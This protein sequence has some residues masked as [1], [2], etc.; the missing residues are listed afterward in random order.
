M[1]N[2]NNQDLSKAL[3]DVLELPTIEQEEWLARLRTSNPELAEEVRAL[4]SVRQQAWFS[5]FLSGRFPQPE[6]AE[7]SSMLG[8]QVGAYEIDGELG[9]GGMGSVWRAHRTDGRFQGTVALKF[10]HASWLGRAGEERFRHEGTLLGR[11]Q[12]PNI[13]RLLDAG[14]YEHQPYLVLEYVE[15][16]PIDTYCEERR[17]NLV[18]RC[19]LFGEVLAAVAHAHSH[20]IVHRDLKPSNILVTTSGDV[21]LLDF[22]LAKLIE[23][24]PDREATQLSAV[25]LTP[26]YASPEQL[27]A[28]PVTTASDV[29]SL[30][31]LLYVVL[32]GRHPGGEVVRMSA[33]W[34]QTIL[35]EEPRRASDCP[36]LD[37]ARRRA[38]QGD[39]DNILGKAL[40]RAPEER[41]G[42][43][44]AFAEDV[45]RYLADEPVHAVADTRVYRIRKFLKRHR[46]GVIAAIL[47]ILALSATTVFALLQMFEAR[48]QR[49]L[50]EY[51]ANHASAQNELTSFLLGDALSEESR[52]A[53]E[54]RLNRAHDMIHRRFAYDKHLQAG[55]L[56][57]L[58]GRYIDAGDM[59]GG[60]AA[61]QEAE[62]LAQSL[63]D[64]DLKASIACG[65]AE[66][67][68]EAGDL[69]AAHRE[70]HEGLANIAR[71]S[72][73]SPGLK[74]SCATATAFIA[75]RENDY[76]KAIAV[77]GETAQALRTAGVEHT[78]RYTSI[79]H[80][81]ARAQVLAGHFREGWQAEEAVIKEVAAL[82][83]EGS[84]GYFAMIN[85]G[86][87]ALMEGGAPLKARALLDNAAKVSS[88]E[89]PSQGL[90]FYL[91][92]SRILAELYAGEAHGAPAKLLQSAATADKE[93]LFTAV[94]TYVSGA[95]RAALDLDD[96]SAAARALEDSQALLSAHP[97][98]RS[99]QL[100]LLA[101]RAR[102]ASAQ[103]DGPKAMRLI[104]QARELIPAAEQRA[105]RAWSILLF[106]AV[107]IEVAQ[108]DLVRASNDAR[109]AVEIARQRAIDP[110]SSRW[111]GEALYW[112]ARIEAA[113]GSPADAR[114]DAA[115]ALSELRA[116]VLPGSLLLLRAQKFAASI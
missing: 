88:P 103:G 51:E 10:V 94:P 11:L 100:R 73:P 60:A 31:L 25:A 115:Q 53:V 24:G 3:D 90:P 91:E 105:E 63:D 86:A 7:T 109:E 6:T 36:E 12:H 65:K 26:Q 41:Y 112:R 111:L 43:A 47:A 110:K 55:L 79:A 71:V 57:G 76:P 64:P 1:S 5:E 66:D 27:L 40:K 69:A 35:N 68:V 50:A 58:S 44:Q 59:K 56:I 83:R 54:M 87:T 89:M 52:E 98:G 84:N 29:Y 32:T 4:L 14:V 46:T 95:V 72:D 17:L 74:A 33:E 15:G 116:S 19:T 2:S 107:E 113:S 16:T 37:P 70:E 101:A 114:A 23:E 18:E 67:A 99:D 45:G 97:L 30:G 42:S 75:E 28:Q 48:E 85:V 106:A 8:R 61:M 39:L 96:P 21:K 49:D 22:G 62:A 77:L 82:G 78:E 108:G 13:A 9:R 80:E 81:Y 20:L 92:A 93:G 34:V 38:L 104:A 102:L